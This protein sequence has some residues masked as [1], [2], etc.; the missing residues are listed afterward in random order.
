[1]NKHSIKSYNRA[2]QDGA[3]LAISLILLVV[4]T[5]LSISAMRSANLDTKI[6]VNH[7]HKQYTF[8]AAES[9]LTR[10]VNLRGE[11]I[12]GIDKPDLET[13]PATENTDWYN[14]GALANSP[15]V[16]ADVT[17]DLIEVSPPGKYKFS[18]YPMD[19]VSVVYRAD[20]EGKVG[21][22]RSTTHNRMDLALIRK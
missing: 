6:A 22:S 3:A 21:E 19:I 13:D 2:R 4:I 20:A 10:I 18:G 14:P 17:M 5:L 9:A 8:Q 16:S 15:D 1:M 11:E 12:Q 7:Q